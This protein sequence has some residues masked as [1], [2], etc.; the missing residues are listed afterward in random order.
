MIKTLN[1][2][3]NLYSKCKMHMQDHAQ[4]LSKFEFSQSIKTWQMT[5]DDRRLNSHRTCSPS[6][7]ETRLKLLRKSHLQLF[8]FDNKITMTLEIWCVNNSCEDIAVMKTVCYGKRK[9]KYNKIRIYKEKKTW[10]KKKCH[11]KW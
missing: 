10:I 9:K 4:Y 5:N 2:V 6:P 11:H 1:T 7:V 8:L 3:D